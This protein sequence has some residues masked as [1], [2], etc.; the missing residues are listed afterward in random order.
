[1]TDLRAHV[2]AARDDGVVQLAPPATEDEV[3]R[4]E[5]EHGVTLPPEYRWF[6]LNAGN[7]GHGPP[8]Y[9]I[10]P[11]SDRAIEAGGFMAPERNHNGR[12]AEPFLAREDDWSEREPEEADEEWAAREAG[13]L[14]LGTDGCAILWVLVLN[15]DARGEVWRL[16]DDTARRSAPTFLDWYVEW[17]DARGP[18][19]GDPVPLALRDKLPAERRSFLRRL[20]R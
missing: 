4:F 12:L 18:K 17:L 20:R 5:V 13:R 15:G 11:L 14:L 3:A 8:Y 9:G 1:V 7:G 19:P 10:E 2:L 6:L 16:G